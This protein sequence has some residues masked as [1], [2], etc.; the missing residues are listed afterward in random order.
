M[1]YWECHKYDFPEYRE[2]FPKDSSA[3]VIRETNGDSVVEASFGI[4]PN[5][6]WSTKRLHNARSET[7]FELPTFAKA[8]RE[9]RC[10]VPVTAFFEQGDKRWVK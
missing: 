9:T 10:V 4:V 6:T 8:A 1:L 3:M 2:A 5:G 7:V